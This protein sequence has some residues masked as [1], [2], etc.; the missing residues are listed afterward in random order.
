[1]ILEGLVTSS[2]ASGLL[3]IAPMGPFFSG[4]SLALDWDRFELRPFQTSKT[5]A[6]LRQHPE[7]VFHL[8]DDALLLAQAAIGRI[9]PIPESRPA[10]TIRGWILTGACRA[11][12]FRVVSRDEGEQRVR[13]KAEVVT[14]H[15]LRE[16]VGLNRGIHAVLEA[17]I[18]ATRVHLLGKDSILEEYRKLGTLVEKTGSPREIRAFTMLDQHVRSFPDPSRAEGI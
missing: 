18:L 10:A 9:D 13:L 6:N 12:E 4:D 8:V 1:M 3:N 7:G 11:Y 16:M 15:S 17:A 5:L 2:D 14:K